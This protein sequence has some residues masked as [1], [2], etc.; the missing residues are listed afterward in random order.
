MLFQQ[1]KISEAVVSIT[2][3]VDRETVHGEA[4][5]SPEKVL[6]VCGDQERTRG[7]RRAGRAGS[8]WI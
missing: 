6:G 7:G 5:E 4:A 1:Q 2:G 8:G 3:K